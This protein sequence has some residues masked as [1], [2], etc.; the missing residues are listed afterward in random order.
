MG[1]G[2]VWERVKRKFTDL[3]TVS[4]SVCP[5]QSAQLLRY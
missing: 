1:P 4:T 2:L 5:L 3:L